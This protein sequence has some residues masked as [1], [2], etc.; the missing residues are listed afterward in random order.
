MY[1]QPSS[2]NPRVFTSY[3][4]GHHHSEAQ[5]GAMAADDVKDFGSLYKEAILHSNPALAPAALASF[6]P[7]GE[8]QGTELFADLFSD[9]SARRIYTDFIFVA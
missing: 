2:S 4:G 9:D 5:G 3:E 7:A 6:V 8:R 1:N